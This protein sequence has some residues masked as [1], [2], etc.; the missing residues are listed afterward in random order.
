MNIE[1]APCRFA[2]QATALD[3]IE[4]GLGFG[5]ADKVGYAGG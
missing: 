1:S 4:S 2:V 3:G 5:V